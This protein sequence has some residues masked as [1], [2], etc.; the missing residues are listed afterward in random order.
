[1]KNETSINNFFLSDG[2]TALPKLT[3]GSLFSG[4]GGFDLA[5]EWIGWENI[6]H[7]EWNE[8]GQRVL[9]HYWPNAK[10]YADITKTDFTIHRGTIDILTGGFPCQPYSSAG[11]RLGKEDDRHLW[12]EML[13][14]IREVQPTYVVGENV[15]GLTNW[16]GGLVFDEVQADLENEGY[17]V[18]PFL[19][20]ACS[21]NAPHRRDRIWFVAYSDA[22]RERR[23]KWQKENEKDADRIQRTFTNTGS[24]R[25][26]GDKEFKEGCNGKRN[27]ISFNEFD[28][29]Y[30]SGIATDTK[31][32]GLEK[33]NA[34][35]LGESETNKNDREFGSIPEWSNFPTQSPVRIRDD[36]FSSR[37]D[38]I[39]FPKWCHESIKAGGN[40][41][42]PQVAYQIFTAINLHLREGRKKNY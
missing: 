4:I 26:N 38:G 34:E 37:L 12:P 9:K 32:R 2:Q 6:F 15:R 24:T 23:D 19:L 3:H 20:P 40:A 21:V 25:R 27:G 10:S 18:T 22:A 30:E 11:K 41:I 8:F 33:R 28:S 16:N 13:R 36:G 1:M 39:T 7:C 31:S 29:L 5:A 42:V 17:E 14:A 35:Q